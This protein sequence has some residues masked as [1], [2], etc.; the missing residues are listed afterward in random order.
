MKYLLHTCCGPCSTACIETLL[1]RGIKPTLFFDNPNIFPDEERA[2]RRNALIKVAEHY[3][4][5][6]IHAYTPHEEWLSFIK[7]YEDEEEGKTRCSLCFAFNAELAS[8]AMKKNGFDTFSTS[9]TVSRFK[10][11]EKIFNEFDKFDSFSKDNFKKNDGFSRSCALSKELNIYRQNYC[12]CEF[13]I[14]SDI[15]RVAYSSASKE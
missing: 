3:S 1:K 9:L 15:V 4:L 11:S 10:N 8:R 6:V 12:G 2:R 7:G 14:N 5:E 13:S